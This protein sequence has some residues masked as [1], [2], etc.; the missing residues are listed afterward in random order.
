MPTR[1]SRAGCVSPRGRAGFAGEHTLG[2]RWPLLDKPPRCT[3][4]QS[5]QVSVPLRSINASHTFT[6]LQCQA[7][8]RD[9]V[10]AGGWRCSAPPLLG[11]ACGQ[12]FPTSSSSGSSPHKGQR[13]GL[14]AECCS[15]TRRPLPDRGVLHLSAV[16]GASGHSRQPALHPE[17]TR[18]RGP[19]SGAGIGPQCPQSRLHPGRPAT[20]AVSLSTS[21]LG[22]G[23]SLPPPRQCC[24]S[25]PSQ[26]FPLKCSGCSPLKSTSCLESE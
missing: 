1:V 13:T 19:R 2:L 20:R 21:A 7:C 6:V 25:R 10:L 5:P 16:P 23:S 14:G 9:S 12:G 26:S 8:A 11:S 24:R 4:G 17:G 3:R 22:P 15:L 18:R